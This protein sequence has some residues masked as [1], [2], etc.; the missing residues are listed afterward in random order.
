M[1]DQR[2]EPGLASAAVEILGPVKSQITSGGLRALAVLG[3]KRPAALPQLP[4]VAE[5]GGPLA[6][7][8]VSSWNALAAPVRIPP[9]I[10]QRLNSE[11]QTVLATPTLRRRLAEI[12][13][14]ARASTPAQLA[15]LLADETR[16]WG[17]VIARAGIPK[18]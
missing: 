6:N 7:F 15:T 17:E 10:V 14:E 13:I 11:L 16:R 8:K 3:A 4:T 18:Q 5:S 12:D 1:R 2:S 9:A